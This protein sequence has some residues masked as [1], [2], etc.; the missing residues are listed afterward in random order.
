MASHANQ[1]IDPSIAPAASNSPN[2]NS[3]GSPSSSRPQQNG[4]KRKRSMA[5]RDQGS[6]TEKGRPTPVKRACNE[7]RQ[8]KLRCDL[9]N[10]PDNTECSR[11]R[12]LNLE[13]RIDANFHRVEKRNKTLEME[14]E[15]MELRQ[16]LSM[17]QEGSGSQAN[18][19]HGQSVSDLHQGAA[20]SLIELRNSSDAP[21]MNSTGIPTPKPRRLGQTTLYP[22]QVKELF[23]EYF[24]KYHPFLPLLDPDK[25][26]D[27]YF[28][29]SELLFWTVI[30]VAA[31][32]YEPDP[33]LLIGLQDPLFSLLWSTVSNVGS[34][35]YQVVKA[36]CLICIWP[37]PTKSTSTDPSFLLSG[38]M[39][40]LALQ[41]GLHRPTHAQDFY[42]IPIDLN[43]DDLKDRL[44]T[45]ACCNIV[46]QNV[47]TMNG[48]P[49]NTHYDFNLSQ[50]KGSSGLPDE[51]WWRL[52]T[53]NFCSKIYSLIYSDKANPIGVYSSSERPVLI[54]VLSDEYKELETEV[55]KLDSF[56]LQ[57]RLSALFD[58][59]D[60]PYYKQD[61]YQL[62]DT[63]TTF[64][65]SA[66]DY[67]ALPYAGAYIL[68]MILAGG[69]VL[70]KLLNSFFSHHT[71]MPSARKLF[72]QTISAI[73]SSSIRNNDLPSRLAEVLTQLW[74]YAGAGVKPRSNEVDDSLQLKG[75]GRLC[76]SIIHDSVIRWRKEFQFNKENFGNADIDTNHPT[77]PN[78]IGV[79]ENE[80]P[81]FSNQMFNPQSLTM[82]SFADTYSGDLN[83][84]LFDPLT[85]ALD[86]D[87]ALSMPFGE[88][89][90]PTVGGFPADPQNM[91]G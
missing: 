80:P 8:Q 4:H 74:H 63:T 40:Q 58:A 47:S 41:S 60:S 45:W 87:S 3:H 1:L 15:L 75:R 88:S 13:C 32:R 70:M 61:L 89:P 79:V 71:D 51:L 5:T 29:L 18:T 68:R 83:F 27:Q 30:G 52:Q 78:P 62:Y 85:W 6:P 9:S 48:Q 67:P 17:Q 31:R 11:C 91:T 36:L 39:M 84:Q 64:L 55:R 69:F 76:L 65:Q 28:E 77:D 37:L 72:N 20:D 81:F 16:R 54:S 38:L 14:R 42:R 12:K 26:P 22:D 57:L 25:T 2:D 24:E 86:N 82:P 21:L 73:R 46:A 34:L 56:G 53:E 33:T 19:T 44:K 10:D 43:E 59:P 50:S 23:D 66:I 35:N 90:A 49:P 7:C